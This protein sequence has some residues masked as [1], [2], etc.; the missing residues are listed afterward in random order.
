MITRIWK[1]DEAHHIVIEFKKG[2]GAVST[3]GFKTAAGA[4][5]GIER[6]ISHCGPSFEINDLPWESHDRLT[7]QLVRHFQSITFT[8]QVK[9]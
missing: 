4:A 7:G 6:L 9:I 3:K 2:T 1:R 8:D 5:K